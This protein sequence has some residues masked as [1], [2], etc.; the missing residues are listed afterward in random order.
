MA[1]TV[2]PP[3]Y[4]ID[5]LSNTELKDWPIG[6]IPIIAS[7]A[8]VKQYI[9]CCTDGTS[10]TKYLLLKY[11]IVVDK[12]GTEWSINTSSR[13]IYKKIG[14]KI[15]Y[16]Y[17]NEL[18]LTSTD[19][20]SVTTSYD[21]LL[22]YPYAYGVESVPML[23][24]IQQ[25]NKTS[26]P[27]L[28][29]FDFNTLFRIDE[30]GT[31]SKI[32]SITFDDHTKKSLRKIL[33]DGQY[34]YI[35][36]NHLMV[37]DMNGTM[38]ARSHINL[39]DMRTGLIVDHMFDCHGNYLALKYNADLKLELCLVTHIKKELVYRILYIHP[40]LALSGCLHIN[41]NNEVAVSFKTSLNVVYEIITIT[42]R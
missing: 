16:S 9:I 38:I 26:I 11:G 24:I 5:V 12:N 18:C 27:I 41:S 1:Y 3:Q 40:R 39:R 6:L 7:Y 42:Y 17:Y 4:Y 31:I 32:S 29:Y 37:I 8:E 25:P 36:A 23:S 22:L 19:K 13:R 2:F 34:I 33:Y 28:L 14:D 21:K 30:N 10:L 15:T 35:L 20:R